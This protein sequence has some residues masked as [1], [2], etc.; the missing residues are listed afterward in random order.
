MVLVTHRPDD[1]A[2]WRSRAALTQLVLRRLSDDDVRAIVRSVAG[3][4]VPE[5]LERLL[6]SK[7]EGSPFCAEEIT[8]ALIE[9]GYLAQNGRGPRLTRPVE[10]IRIPGTVQ[11]VIAARL[12]RLGPQAK[13]VVQVASVLG[14]QFQRHQLAQLLEGEGIDLD[15][16]LEELERRGLFHRKS[17]LASNEYRFGESVTQEVAYEGLLHKLRRQ[18]HERIAF[19]LEASGDGAGAERAALLAHHLAR[20]DNRPK[21]IEA[22]QQAGLE[23]E[24][25][26]SYRAAVDFYRRAW[27]LAEAEL[28]EGGDGQFRRAA[29]AATS[30]IARLCA[31]FGAYHLVD[32]ERAAR[33]G[34]ELAEELGDHEALATL[35]YCHGVLIMHGGQEEFAR[36]LTVAEEGMAVAERAGLQLSALRLSR[37]LAISYCHDGRFDL[38]HRAIE[39]ATAEVARRGEPVLSDIALS[40]RWVADAVAHLCDDFDAALEG[41]ATTYELA[42]R[43]PNR[44]VTSG[45]TGT[46]AQIHFLRAEYAE[47]RRWADESLTV[48]EAITNVAS[49]P[50]AAAVALAARNELGEPADVAHFLDLIEQ[51]IANGG[52]VQTHVRLLADA[53][54]GVDDLAV[55]ARFAD[56]LRAST[57]G[58]RFRLAGTAATLGELLIRVGRHADAE[59][60]FEEAIG[61]AEAIGSRSTL[62]AASLGAAELAAVR[63]DHATVRRLLERV[64]TISHQLSLRHFVR[65]ATRL[66]GAAEVQTA[67][68]A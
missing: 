33:R 20:S 4:A 68:G 12:D 6:V 55:I 2:A 11:E 10:E 44:T 16:E 46:L 63:G 26:P 51:G 5:Q 13:R 35:C 38:A 29:L 42:V 7:A 23:A 30:G 36:G 43:A 40:T 59:R 47:A 54:R 37:G 8:R 24:R 19:L 41:A 27:E 3:G 31:L 52:T 48:A 50:G 65:R 18:L 39:W 22:L 67:R 53:L 14:R 17:L 25:L 9:E 21:A 58:G 28:A 64:T 60:A 62:A 34:R 32:A 61:L 66:L 15:R 49:Y 57:S 56:L 1:R 45:T